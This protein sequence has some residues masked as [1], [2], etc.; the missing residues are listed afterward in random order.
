MIIILGPLI[1]RHGGRPPTWTYWR[2]WQWLVFYSRREESVCC[3]NYC[4]GLYLTFVNN[5]TWIFNLVH[6]VISQH[7]CKT[8]RITLILR[9]T[10][11]L[12]KLS[13]TLLGLYYTQWLHMSVRQNLYHL[14]SVPYY[15]GALFSWILILSWEINLPSLIRQLASYVKLASLLWNTERKK[16]W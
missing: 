14:R 11:T 9:E 2:P 5:R 7:I 12:K 3:V 10:I 6:I 1:C 16:N 4:I 13:V 8:S 15:S